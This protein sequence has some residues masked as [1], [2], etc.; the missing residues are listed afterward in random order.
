MDKYESHV[1]NN[2][3]SADGDI[4]QSFSVLVLIFSETLDLKRFS[5]FLLKNMCRK[6]TFTFKNKQENNFLFGLHK[7]IGGKYIININRIKE[8]HFCVYI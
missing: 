1:L 2:E 7:K 8:M 4:Y 6:Y 5:I 3:L